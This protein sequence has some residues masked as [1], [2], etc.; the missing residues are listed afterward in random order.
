MRVGWVYDRAFLRHRTPRGHPE[1]P[2]RL[3]ALV[4]GLA[5][6]GLLGRMTPL[7]FSPAPREVLAWVHE[8][9]YVELVR[10]ACE[11][12]MGFLGSRDTPIGPES[13]PAARLAAGGVLAACDE[14]AKG[15]IDRAFCAVRPPGHHAEPDRAGGFCLF[16]HAALAAE[17]LRRT[18]GLPRVAII[19][20]DVHH[21]QGTQRIF[22]H[23]RDV[24]YVSLHQDPETLYPGTGRASERGTGPGEGFTLNVPMPAGAGDGE[25]RGAFADRVL[26]AVEAF[27]PAAVVISAGFDAAAADGTADI[28]LTPDCFGWM[29]RAVA[30]VADRH[31][32][33]RI[34]SV[35][36]GGYEPASLARCATAHVAALLG[37][38]FA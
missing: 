21:G 8:P 9:A 7:T 25:Y 16:N 34:V 26:P 15:R 33:G 35:L 10:L 18:H 11:Q 32:C 28:R 29:T 31:G 30:E 17:R 27:A 24:L 2:R 6:A 5:E 36:E 3:E 13:E 38:S 22:E 19:D 4:A 1:S 12:D 20:W 14:I 37:E 23:R